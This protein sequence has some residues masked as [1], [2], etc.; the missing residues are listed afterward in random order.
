MTN[1]FKKIVH[2][3]ITRYVLESS[4]GGGTSSGSVASVST[5]LS[6]VQRRPKDSI[7]AQEE[8]KKEAPKPRNFV[9][10]NAKMGGA[11]QH[12]DKKKEMKQGVEKH[13]KPYM[14]E[15]DDLKSQFMAM[16]KDKGIKHRVR[17]TPDQERQRTADMIANRSASTS[18]APVT[19]ATS[20][21]YR[22]GVSDG[23]RGHRNPRA[24]SIYGP[25]TNDYDSGYH[26]GALKRQQGVAE[27]Q[28]SELSVGPKIR[29]Y[30]GRS[31]Y[32]NDAD[33]YGDDDE[34][35]KQSAKADKIRANIQRK[36]G[37]K[38][39]QH[40]DRAATSKIAG[41]FHM[42][43][44]KEGNSGEEYNDEV[45]M[46]T[47]NIHTII[48]SAKELINI[49]EP[50]ENMPEWAQDKLA[51]VKGMLVS[52]KDYIES[53]HEEGNI[54]HT[55]EDWGKSGYD[56]YA[57]GNHGRGVMEDAYIAEL[58]A[59]LAEKIPS[60]APVDV[61]IKDFEK[62]NAPQFK[63]KTKE[64]RR[65]MAIAASYGAKNPSKKK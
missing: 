9:A 46:S 27:D 10:K 51:Q 2:G 35:E 48:R 18:S 22:D 5:A 60:N 52:V 17:G 58:V 41:R 28:I 47:S 45:G 56:T 54:Y 40:A 31:D 3:D 57:G 6:G 59:K 25:M 21:A 7:F 49:L 20:G 44:M 24:S 61:W 64:K 32:A 53:Q 39:A 1:E 29:A 63:G 13:K 33:H 15:V 38:A 42:Q 12:K 55:D 62:S 23:M 4:S 8:Q 65:Q 34:T 37:D 36:H 19:L 43:P 26:A 11:G 14:E 16:L 50:M 30:A